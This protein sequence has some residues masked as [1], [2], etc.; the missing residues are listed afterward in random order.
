[1]SDL[2]SFLQKTP[3]A[4]MFY[5][6]GNAQSQGNAG[7][8]AGLNAYQSVQ[9]ENY[10][11]IDYQGPDSAPGV[12]FNPAT[13]QQV[14]SNA[15][16][17]IQ[18]DP[19]L[20]QAQNAQLSALQQLSQNGGM[21]A[22]D[23]ANLASIQMQ[24]NQNTNAQRQA[25]QQNAQMRGAGT[26]GAALLGQ[27]VANQGGANNQSAQDMQVAGMAQNRALQA[28]EGAGNLAGNMNAQQWQQQAAAAAAQNQIN[29]FNAQQGNQV[30]EFNSEGGLNAGE[31]NSSQEQGVL[32][33]RAAAN[34]QNQYMNNYEIPTTQYGQAMQ[35]AGGETTAG[36]GQGSYYNKQQETNGARQSGIWG[37]AVQGLT[38]AWPAITGAFSGGGEEAGGAGAMGSEYGAGEAGEFTGE[39]GAGSLTYGLD[40]A[41]PVATAW[42]GKIPGS[43][44]VRGDSPIND[45]QMIKT[46][47]GE[48][49]VPR[50]LAMGG[51]KGQIGQFVKNPPNA[52]APDRQ[53]EAMLSALKQIR[54]RGGI[55]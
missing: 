45:T 22:A 44:P 11:P 23:K 32:N 2:T 31:F 8:E 55:R 48:V 4:Q 20:L 13:A 50:S 14:G 16:G 53:K 3:L 28:S 12:N 7:A 54:S 19:K 21:N 42:G 39:G 29:A 36:L 10:K 41:A 18:T 27:M 40:T 51:T 6:N 49:V 47:P 26:G 34:N 30:G 5:N 25:L 17:N 24:Q 38:S 37:G 15:Y 43:A 35:K 46:S 1:M 9:P 33:A 52:F